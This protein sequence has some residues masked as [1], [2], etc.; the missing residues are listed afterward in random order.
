MTHLGTMKSGHHGFFLTLP[1]GKKE[2]GR[3][4]NVVK[5]MSLFRISDQVTEL[6]L[7]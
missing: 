2:T 4:K 1:P 6:K 3:F 7:L 5:L